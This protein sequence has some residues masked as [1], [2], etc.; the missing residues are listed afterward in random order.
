MLLALIVVLSGVLTALEYTV[1]DS[2]N[3]AA[4]D[5]LVDDVEDLQM[6][7]VPEMENPVAVITPVAEQTAT[8]IEIVIDEQLPDTF[9][10]P[11][12]AAVDEALNND[13]PPPVDIP[14]TTEGIGD[15]NSSAL[16][17]LTT[18]EPLPLRVVE[19]LP[20][21]PGGQA[22]FIEWLTRRLHFPSVPS[23]MNRHLV[24]AS[25]IVN[26][27]G[28][29]SDLSVLEP[30]NTPF[31]REVLRVLK[32]MPDWK[33]GFMHAKPCRTLVHIPIDFRR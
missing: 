21:F 6:L 29:V 4:D 22:V 28:K 12:I 2:V 3:T 10:T 13:V 25:F 20:E 26:A 32:T 31:E 8:E 18:D 11:V 33:P 7:P 24:T 1:N 14:T 9:T 16:T 23:S 27:D 5:S 19:Q 15:G 30:K 17:S